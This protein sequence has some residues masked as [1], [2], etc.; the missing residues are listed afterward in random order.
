MS[1]Y[2]LIPEGLIYGNGA[3]LEQ[4]LRSFIGA[5]ASSL[6][7]VCDFDRTLTVRKPGSEG[8]VT[9]WSILAEHLPIGAQQEHAAL[10]DKYRALE[11]TE[12]MTSDDA[13]D[14]WTSILK[15]FVKHKININKIEADFLERASVRLGTK[16]LFQACGKQ[17]VPTVI[18]S[19]GIRDVIDVWGR[20]YDIQPTLTISTALILDKEGTIIGWDEQTL[21]H[22]LNKHEADHPKLESIRQSRPKAIIVGDG[23]SDADMA[24]GA[25]D[26]LRIRIY[27][28]RADE[29]K[30]LTKMRSETLERFDAIIESGSLDP[31]QSIVQLIIDG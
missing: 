23:M 30:D 16:E 26:V 4:K 28:P 1:D 29:A 24:I 9:T 3:E 18:M 6:H 20:A 11:T 2:A 27:D 7:L 15:L 22:T 19:A 31:L 17:N 12:T 13:V 25:E 14:W 21:V 8:D 10:Y 5:G